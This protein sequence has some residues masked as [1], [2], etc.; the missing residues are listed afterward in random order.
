LTAR[1]ATRADGLELTGGG[2][3]LGRLTKMVVEGAPEGMMDDHVS[4]RM[5]ICREM[6]RYPSGAET[7]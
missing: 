4:R 3:L 5:T 1:H 6:E 7:K 2:G